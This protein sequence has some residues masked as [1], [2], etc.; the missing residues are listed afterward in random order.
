M[1]LFAK[2]KHCKLFLISNKTGVGMK[3]INKKNGIENLEMFKRSRFFRKETKF[4]GSSLFSKS[5]KGYL[6][7]RTEIEQFAKEKNCQFFL[8]SNKTG[9]GMKTK[10][11]EN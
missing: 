5:N 2:E 7:T 3:K 1:E 11:K 10:K 6:K 9:V 8:I 4:E